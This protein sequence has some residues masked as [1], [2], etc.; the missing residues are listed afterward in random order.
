MSAAEEGRSLGEL[1]ASAADELSGLVHDEIALA[2]AQVKQDVQRAL[3]GIIAIAVGAVLALFA[4]ALLSFAAADGLHEWWD[5]PIGVTTALVGV[6]YL[7]VTGALVLFAVKKF[8]RLGSAQRS[9]RSAKSSAAVL[10]GVR[11]HPRPVP[12]DKAGSAT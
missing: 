7:A 10:A 1:V 12:V 2:K 8:S 4:L 5:V 6:V 3:W 9:V 11:P